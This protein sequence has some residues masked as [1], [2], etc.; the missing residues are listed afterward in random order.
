M[1]SSHHFN[2]IILY[3]VNIKCCYLVSYELH[4]VSLEIFCLFRIYVVHT[5]WRFLHVKSYSL[6]IDMKSTYRFRTMKDH[7]HGFF[8]CY[9]RRAI[10]LDI[11][12]Y[13]VRERERERDSLSTKSSQVCLSIYTGTYTLHVYMYHIV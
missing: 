6:T 1:D 7:E 2:D 5:M 13:R 8:F 12:T 10:L 9:I 11:Y 4:M 3:G